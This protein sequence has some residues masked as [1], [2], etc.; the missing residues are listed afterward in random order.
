M[1]P[2]RF[3]RHAR[4][5]MRLYHISDSIVMQIIGEQDFTIGHYEFIEDVKGF[6]LP[7][8]VVFDVHEQ[9]II[10]ITAYP[11]KGKRNERDI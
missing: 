1:K 11:L 2:I 6:A 8:K 5:R 4:R 10:V 3:S 9:E 7:V